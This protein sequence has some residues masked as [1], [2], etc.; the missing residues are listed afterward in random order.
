MKPAAAT[1]QNLLQ[2]AL[3]ILETAVPDP[4]SRTGQAAILLELGMLAYGQ[5]QHE[6]AERYF[7]QSLIRCRLTGDRWGEANVLCE[8]GVNAWIRGEYDEAARRYGQS[9]AIREAL[10]D[11]VGMA[12][13][14]E[15]LAG[16]AMTARDGGAGDC[17]YAAEFADL[18]PVRR[19]G[20]YGR[21][22][23]RI[24]TQELVSTPDRDRVD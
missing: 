16:T 11:H 9:L 2:S 12:V 13:A 14:L 20:R 1:R 19:P 24:G 18:S 21:A 5:G 3:A 7:E 22:A 8:M 6:T 17:L 23:S 10:Q 4:N 15:G